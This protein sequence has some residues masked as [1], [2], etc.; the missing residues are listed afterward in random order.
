MI[1]LSREIRKI[2]ILNSGKPGLPGRKDVW[3]PG[4]KPESRQVR[5]GGEQPQNSPEIFMARRIS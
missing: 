3:E 1:L 4:L 5:I 2:L